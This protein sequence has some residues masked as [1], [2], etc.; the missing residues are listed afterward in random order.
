MTADKAS[1]NERLQKLLRQKRE[2]DTQ[3]NELREGML[4]LNYYAGGSASTFEIEIMRNGS[5]ST[6]AVFFE[7]VATEADAKAAYVAICQLRGFEP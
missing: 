1:R 5:N 2:I 3:I 7:R 4:Q 6:M